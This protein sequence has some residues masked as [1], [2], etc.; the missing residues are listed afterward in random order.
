MSYGIISDETAM[1]LREDGFDMAWNVEN[2]TPIT[3]N[4]D[5]VV[6]GALDESFAI[7]DMYH[8]EDIVQCIAN[9]LRGNSQIQ[10]WEVHAYIPEQ[11][12][13]STRTSRS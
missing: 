10:D 7:N 4:V 5:I 8:H 11:E 12:T 3:V 2:H 13:L 9:H 6:E 1:W